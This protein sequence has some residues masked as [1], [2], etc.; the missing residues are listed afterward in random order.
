MQ[1]SV[2]IN[3]GSAI[4]GETGVEPGISRPL[5]AY[6]Q[7]ALQTG[8]RKLDTTATSDSLMERRRKPANPLE[9]T[10]TQQRGGVSILR[11]WQILDPSVASDA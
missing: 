11:R 1:V 4:S 2:R 3:A 6:I 9:E 10:Y 8:G 5:Y 7:Y